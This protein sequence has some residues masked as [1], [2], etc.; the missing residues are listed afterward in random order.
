[1]EANAMRIKSGI[2]ALTGLALA[3][4]PINAANASM[5]GFQLRLTVPVI[6]HITDAYAPNP[7]SGEILL[8]TSCNA[9][10]Y[11]IA[12]GGDLAGIGVNDVSA[13]QGRISSFGSQLSVQ[14][15]RPG[16]N[17]IR[18]QMSGDL[19]RV[20]SAYFHIQAL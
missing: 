5:L 8:E 2:V 13:T 20:Q 18:V 1:M 10:R 7:A 16:R 3:I 9:E 12:L 17:T 4:M 11:A 15:D 19:S 6:C 14:P